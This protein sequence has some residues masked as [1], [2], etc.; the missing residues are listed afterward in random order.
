VR[1]IDV[2]VTLSLRAARCR[3]D[4][5][6][7]VDLEPDGELASETALAL[8]RRDLRWTGSFQ[9]AERGGQPF[10]YRLGV[11]AHTG[12]QFWLR[13]RERG[14]LLLLEDGDVLCVAKCILVGT[15]TT[16]A[17]SARERRCAPRLVLVRA[18][19]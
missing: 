4:V 1:F 9:F 12:A 18:G 2:E 11:V 6:L 17:V 16:A 7:W 5:R 8:E 3:P 15:C 19:A 13:M 14:G 10:F